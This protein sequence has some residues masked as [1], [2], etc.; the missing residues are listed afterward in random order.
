MLDSIVLLLSFVE[1]FTCLCIFD[2]WLKISINTK[3]QKVLLSIVSCVSLGV[4]DKIE[5]GTVIGTGIFLLIL[6]FYG[7]FVLK[8]RFQE[9]W[10]TT[11]V[12]TL[13]LIIVNGFFLFIGIITVGSI[14]PFLSD[15]DNF[16]A[17]IALLSSK[18]FLLLEYLYLRSHDIEGGVFDKVTWKWIICI[19]VVSVLN[20]H[21]CVYGYI[22]HEVS[23]RGSMMHFILAVITN[24]LVYGLCVEFSKN[25]RKNK[26]HLM[27][28]EAIRYEQRSKLEMSELVEKM[29]RVNHDFDKHMV[30][31]K[32]LIEDGESFLAKEY[33]D[34]ISMKEK[35][36][37]FDTG[38]NILNYLLGKK[39]SDAKEQGI[40]VHYMILGNKLDY[41]DDVDMTELVGNLLDNAIDAAL[42]SDEKKLE[43]KFDFNEPD[44][45]KFVVKNSYSHEIKEHGKTLSST[46]EDSKNHGLGMSVIS[47]V[48]QS[49]E[50]QDY[51]RY[52]DGIFTHICILLNDEKV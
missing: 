45:S 34:R 36:L 40:E 11:L 4:V 14:E 41:I 42:Q 6:F 47:K 25:A 18:L 24:V 32:G 16:V 50:G 2:A 23:L 28:L 48:V 29:S 8:S 49:Y 31:I 22:Y 35:C 46:K 33:V 52:E 20:A 13:N 3:L 37:V 19:T 21:V 17:Y 30:V 39:L 27:L 44:M 10:M 7:F 5:G 9:V 1:T 38:S 43:I 51:Y 12:C 26:R 15:S